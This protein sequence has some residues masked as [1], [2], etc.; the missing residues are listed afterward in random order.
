MVKARFSPYETLE[1]E[2]ECVPLAIEQSKRTVEREFD[3]HEE[4]AEQ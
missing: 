4:L 3:N 2:R 1:N